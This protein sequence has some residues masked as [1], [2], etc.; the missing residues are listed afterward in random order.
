MKLPRRR[1][2]HLAAGAA[3]LPAVGAASPALVTG[4]EGADCCGGTGARRKRFRGSPRGRDPHQPI[5]PV[6]TGKGCACSRSGW[7][8][9]AS[10]G[11]RRRTGW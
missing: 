5:V 1:F 9:A 7:N 10:S 4:G 2:L 11:P 8:G 6:V 3:A